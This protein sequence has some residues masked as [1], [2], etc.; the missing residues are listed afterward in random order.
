MASEWAPSPPLGRW[1]PHFDQMTVG[2]ADVTTDLVLVLFRR[3]HEIRTRALHS[4]YAASM[5]LTWILRKLLTR[6]K[7]RGVS[8]MTAGL[9]SIHRPH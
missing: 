3:R 7:S 9:S 8:R 5:S 1:L 2:I 6:S 4:A